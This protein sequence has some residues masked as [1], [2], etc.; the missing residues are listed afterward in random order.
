MNKTIT[1]LFLVLTISSCE[2]TVGEKVVGNEA[3]FLLSVLGMI[4]AIVITNLARGFEA[5]LRWRP[6]TW[7]NSLFKTSRW[8]LRFLWGINISF[9]IIQLVWGM[10]LNIHLLNIWYQLI[11]HLILCGIVYIIVIYVFPEDIKDIFKKEEEREHQMYWSASIVERLCKL[12]K[13]LALYMI[14]TI[15]ISIHFFITQENH[16][17]LDKNIIGICLKIPCI[18]LFHIAI[19][20]K[21]EQ[22]KLLE[23]L[24]KESKKVNNTK[25]IIIKL[26]YYLILF[27][28]LIHSYYFAIRTY[29]F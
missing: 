26:D 29:E 12:Y 18:I 17:A 20:K 16:S 15:I 22:S 4:M 14:T 24:G 6:G 8:Q 7:S 5:I 3:T 9:L 21:L 13:M 28:A 10:R 11:Y 1:F 25:N 27:S 19:K 23:N 2:K